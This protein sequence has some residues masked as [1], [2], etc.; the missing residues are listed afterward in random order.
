MK[1]ARGRITSHRA[2]ATIATQLYNSKEP[3]TLFELQEWLGHR[4]A[5]STQ[6]YAKI[7][8]TRLAKAYEKAGY[9]QRNLRMVEV[10]VDRE[11]VVSG[12]ACAWPCKSPQVWP[13][14]VPTP[15]LT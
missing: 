15:R 12:A 6:Q 13:T 3:L 8:P 10:L 11:A 7:A 1:D 5:D 14:K 4:R 2:R 9:F